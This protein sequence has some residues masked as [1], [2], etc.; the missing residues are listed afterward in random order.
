M[1]KLTQCL[2]LNLL[3]AFT[4]VAREDIKLCGVEWPPFTFVVQGKMV[5]GISLD[6]YREAFRRLSHN[7]STSVLP[8]ARCKL[9]VIQGDE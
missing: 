6:V 8:W 2:I 3:C 5:K 1:R 7:S 4:S 9:A